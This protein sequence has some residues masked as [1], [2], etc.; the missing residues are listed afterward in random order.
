[1]TNPNYTD[2]MITKTEVLAA[3]AKALASAFADWLN[4]NREEVL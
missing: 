2:R 4:D 3:G 1:M